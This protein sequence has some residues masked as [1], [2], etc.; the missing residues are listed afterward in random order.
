MV[1]IFINNERNDTK[2]GD[3][4][5]KKIL[6]LFLCFL[7]LFFCAGCGEKEAN[8]KGP[9]PNGYYYWSSEEKNT[10]IYTESDIREISGWVIKGDTAEHWASDTVHYKAKIVEKDGKIFFEGYKWEEFL[11]SSKMGSENIYEVIYDETEKSFETITVYNEY[12]KKE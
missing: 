8:S 7:T 3:K 9:I 6:S 4:Q 11:V 12:D 2:K 1:K 5:M 10:L